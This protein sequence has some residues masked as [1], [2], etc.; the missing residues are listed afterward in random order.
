MQRLSKENIQFIDDYLK[1]NKV[2]HW[3]VRME[4]L[5]HVASAVE[6]E[7]AK[8]VS[9]DRALMSVHMSFGNILKSKKLSK[10]QKSWIFT[11]SIYADNSGYKK[12][13]AVKHS[14]IKR[15]LRI[16]H[17]DA[18]FSFFKNPLLLFCYTF[19]LY[20]LFKINGLVYTE[21][22]F[23]SLEAIICVTMCIPLLVGFINYLKHGKSIYLSVLSGMSL[24]A[25]Y[26]SWN[27]LFYLPKG[28]LFGAN[29]DYA[30]WYFVFMCAILLPFL[31]MQTK[32]F[33]VYLSKLKKFQSKLA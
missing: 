17:R 30:H 32:V 13:I 10:D 19:G 24:G 16:M 25:V 8:G 28:F 12:F 11:E 33:F 23:A 27:I 2:T 31:F 26:I 9:F 1:K 4:L 18:L 22:L 7:M 21:T 20:I 3:D 5:D 29:K 14:L 6:E 15:Q